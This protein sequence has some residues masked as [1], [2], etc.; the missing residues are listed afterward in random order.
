[1]DTETAPS[2]AP[3]PAAETSPPS[4]DAVM[5]AFSASEESLVGAPPDPFAPPAPVPGQEA[6]P[7]EAAP[8]PSPPEP[9]PAQA[10]DG[11]PGDRLLRLMEAERALRER[12]AQAAR[13]EQ[14]AQ[15]RLQE[16][17]QRTSAADRYR[18]LEEAVLSKD[19]SAI[20]EALEIDPVD[21]AESLQT[22]RGADPQR[23]IERRMNELL[24]E[25]TRDLR[26][27]QQRLQ[28]QLREQ[29]LDQARR[30]VLDMARTHAPALA[31]LA[32]VNP[33]LPDAVIA[34]AQT[35]QRETGKIP[36]LGTVIPALQQEAV[37][38]ALSVFEALLPHLDSSA[39]ERVRG[40][41]APQENTPAQ[42]TPAQ[43]RPQLTL[44]NG[45]A[46]QESTF[47][48]PPEIQPGADDELD[49]YLRKHGL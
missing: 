38:Q 24:E 49:A 35:L 43:R 25:R 30:E 34:R 16:A 20:A 14:E 11:D 23:L 29:T 32:A 17:E 9:E 2:P 12:E 28:N 6:R 8:P 5:A 42:V 44:T 39:M 21:L 7:P 3:A 26:E 15:A 37:S 45:R 1:M 40:L 10:G 31:A 46:A 18:R 33:D 4:L 13:R 48:A 47:E 36:D 22:G 19:A 27:S 41:M